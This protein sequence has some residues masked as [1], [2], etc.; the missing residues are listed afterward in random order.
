MS[1]ER[2]HEAT[3]IAL[4]RHGYFVSGWKGSGILELINASGLFVGPGDVTINDDSLHELIELV[5]HAPVGLTVAIDLSGTQ[6]T[7][8]GLIELQRVTNLGRLIVRNSQI[9]DEG[10]EKMRMRIG[11]PMEMPPPFNTDRQVSQRTFDTPSL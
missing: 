11:I 3:A 8:K 5:N 10:I 9:T 4:A 1:W 2:R 7:D 6:V